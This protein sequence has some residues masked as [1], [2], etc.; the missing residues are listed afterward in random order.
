MCKDV[1]VENNG[2][3]WRKT[4]GEVWQKTTAK[5]IGE[6]VAKYRH[7]LGMTAQQLAE[8]CREL[9][10]PIHRT[11]ITKIENGRSRF[12]LAELLI[13]AAALDVPPIALIYPGLPDDM[14]AI[15][16]GKVGTSWEAYMWAT[17]MAASPVPRTQ[18]PSK[19]AQLV[20]AVR[21]R[22]ELIRRL[23][24]LQLEMA[25]E[26]AT[27]RE[28]RE[29]ELELVRDEIN[30]LNTLIHSVGGVLKNV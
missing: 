12:D 19:G 22:W 16:P 13:L 26:D 23:P 3:D 2:E 24:G 29:Y 30:Q 5:R 6:A 8:R 17:G 10:V 15:V 21:R 11:T 14:V 1:G 28:A 18:S 4:L 25:T 27:L 7:D 20:D 9:G